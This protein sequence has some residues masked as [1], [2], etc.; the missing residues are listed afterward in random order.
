MRII[1]GQWRGRKLPFPTVDGLRPTGDRIRETLFNWLQP[2][3]PGAH[4][5]D[6]F[7]GAGALGFE[8]LSREVSSVTFV[9]N[10]SI[11]AGQLKANGKLLQTHN[12]HFICSDSLSW[13]KQTPPKTFDIVFLDPPFAADFLQEVANLLE[14]HQWLSDN[15]AIYV[16]HPTEQQPALPANWQLHRNKS[17]GA[18]IYQL[19]YR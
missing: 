11:V 15:A 8:A 10:S 2:D 18:V 17:A 14:E 19:Y 3:L 12:A 16:E 5:L 9:D 6:L 13:L 7:A 4:C 1:G